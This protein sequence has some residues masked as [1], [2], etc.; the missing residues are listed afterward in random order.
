VVEWYVA[1]GI[2]GRLAA[3][4]AAR[5]EQAAV[6]ASISRLQRRVDG[7]YAE[8]RHFAG[9]LDE[10]TAR[11]ERL[12][13]KA[14]SWFGSLLY[15]NLD[16]QVELL[17]LETDEVEDRFEEA[18]RNFEAARDELEQARRRQ[19]ELAAGSADYDAALQDKEKRLL[20]EGDPRAGRL[21]EIA[22]EQERLAGVLQDTD[23]LLTSISWSDRAL[24]TLEH[25]ITS[26]RRFALT[27]LAG[28]GAMAGKAKYDELAAVSNAAAY[29]EQCLGKLKDE[30]DVYGERQSLV[31]G[32]PMDSRA[33]FLDI[34]LD[35]PSRDLQSF[36]K[37]AE[38]QHRLPRTRSL[39]QQIGDDLRQRRA[40]VLTT[41]DKLTAERQRLLAK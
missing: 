29:A 28:G 31:T 34:W 22:A 5:Q 13:G 35:S 16:E 8:T 12:E 41:V 14:R 7:L 17:R 18:R 1:E 10:L 15:R 40:E 30:L 36:L 3:G 27:D 24:D 2:E 6:G 33:R 19:E 11:L 21:A 23:D 20:A 9:R 4:L 25:L 32:E 38:A 39:L 26:A 37:V